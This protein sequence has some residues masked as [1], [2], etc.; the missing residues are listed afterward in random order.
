[1]SLGVASV[2]TYGMRQF[3]VLR[4]QNLTQE[5]LLQAAYYTRSFLSQAVKAT[6]CQ[7]NTCYNFSNPVSNPNYQAIADTFS[8]STPSTTGNLDPA[9]FP[10][11]AIDCRNEA[12]GNFA[13]GAKSTFGIFARESGR[14]N[15]GTVATAVPESLF[16]ATGIYFKAPTAPV[17][18]VGQSGVLYLGT[19]TAANPSTMMTDERALFFDRLV[20]VGVIPGSVKMSANPLNISGTDTYYPI[21][22]MDL[23]LVARYFNDFSNIDYRPGIAAGAY[24]DIE[25]IV[26]IGF[27]NNVISMTADGSVVS[28]SQLTTPER[29]HGGLYYYRLAAPTLQAMQS[30]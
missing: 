20:N 3:A 28:G 8:P 25:M 13:S 6:C 22:S 11:G 15:G 18:G 30:F 21:Q 19:G 14:L 4:E 2:F 23:R 17:G 12:A 29:L 26:S 9:G 5:S 16:L 1:V 10:V 7:G 27:R 24:R